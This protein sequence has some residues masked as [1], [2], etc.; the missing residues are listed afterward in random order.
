MLLFVA[1]ANSHY[2]LRGPF[3]VLV[4]RVT[5]DGRNKAGSQP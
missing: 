3:E 5:L 2:F 1:L 4:R